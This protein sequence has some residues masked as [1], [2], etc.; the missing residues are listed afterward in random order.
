MREANAG[1]PARPAQC[2]RTATASRTARQARGAEPRK[3]APAARAAQRCRARF[4]SAEFLHG[5]LGP[6]FRGFS[7][8]LRRKRGGAEAPCGGVP[9]LHGGPGDA[10]FPASAGS[11]AAACA[12]GVSAASTSSSHPIPE[13]REFRRKPGARGFR[14]SRSE[15]ECV[16]SVC[17]WFPSRFVSADSAAGDTEAHKR[18][19]RFLFHSARRKRCAAIVYHFTASSI[20]AAFSSIDA[21]FPGD[22]GVAGALKKLGSLVGASGLFLALRMRAWICRQSAMSKHCSSRGEPIGQSGK[23]RMLCESQTGNPCQMRVS[24]A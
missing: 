23:L 5:S 14:A 8:R 18:F 17:K 16:S 2:A 10:F 1:S 12:A 19:F 13:L 4:G 7:K 22:H 11:P 15:S 6:R 20:C 21:E 3:P 24:E 9:G